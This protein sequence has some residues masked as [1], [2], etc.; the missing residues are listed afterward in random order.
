MIALSDAVQPTF[1]TRWS[2]AYGGPFPLRVLEGAE[3]QIEIVRDGTPEV[4]ST[5]REFMVALHGERFAKRHW[6]LDRYLT[7]GRYAPPVDRYGPAITLVGNPLSSPP[8]FRIT[9][10]KPVPGID[11][12]ARGVEVAKLL[13]A[14]FQGWIT[15]SGFEFG[16]VLQEVYRKIL[17][18]N[19][20]KSPWNPQRSS[21]GHYVHLVCRSALSNLHRREKRK[22]EKEQL[23]LPG[24]GSD[25]LWQIV[26]A[27]GV[28]QDIV[29]KAPTHDPVEDL[30]DYIRRGPYAEHALSGTA[31]RLV[32]FVQEGWTLK[33]AAL[34]LGVTR[35]EVG[36]A[37]RLLRRAATAWA[38]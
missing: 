14:G 13:R 18:A 5:A 25:G 23:G 32:P 1:H 26:D 3:R 35:A 34:A 30:Q 19:R 21:F 6:T 22:R 15:T 20:G 16:D 37:N 9:V 17:V 11:L 4:F 29:E 7:R 12:D 38:R 31:A 10:A 27:S 24:V 33:D 2:Q 36:K 8:D 28:A